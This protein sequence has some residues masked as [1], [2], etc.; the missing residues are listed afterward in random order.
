MSTGLS[1]N[2]S[3][4]HKLTKFKPRASFQLNTLKIRKR[5]KTSRRTELIK[6]TH[7]PGIHTYVTGQ[8]GAGTEDFPTNIN[9]NARVCELKKHVRHK[10][11]EVAGV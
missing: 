5:N 8:K 2:A 9:Q 10:E 3:P 11:V 7:E 6:C 4:D 1:G